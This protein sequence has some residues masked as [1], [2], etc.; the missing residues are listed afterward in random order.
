MKAKLLERNTPE[1]FIQ[2]A[3]LLLTTRS[4]SEVNIYKAVEI[5][6]CSINLLTGLTIILRSATKITHKAQAITCLAAKWHVCSTIDSYE[7]VESETPVAIINHN[8]S[9][10]RG[11]SED[12]GEEFDEDDLD[13]TK[14]IPA[15]ARSTIS[16]QKRQALVTYFDKNRAGIS[17][18]G[19]VLDRGYLHTIFG[20]EFSLVLW[21]L[22]KTIAS[23]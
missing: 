20:I 17:L 10:S 1:N 23:V 11:S 3:S 22:G 19:F 7:N 9:F 4:G 15:Y 16:F 12:D 13:N 21:L 18:Y 6:L 8:P 2:F 5:T 14:M